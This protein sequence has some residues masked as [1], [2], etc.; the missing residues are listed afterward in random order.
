MQLFDVIPAEEPL[1]PILIS[2]PHSGVEFPSEIAEQIRPELVAKPN[3]TDWFVDQLYDFAPKMGITLIKANLS[4]Y[5][6][7]LNRSPEN[8]K[9]YNDDR[10][11]FDLVPK[12]QFNLESIYRDALPNAEEIE[13]RKQQ[14]F[15][16]YYQ[17]ISQLLQ[18]LRQQF[19]QVIFFD[20]HSIRHQVKAIDC[21][22]FPDLVLGDQNGKTAAPA[23]IQKTVE[24]L[25]A[26]PFEF[27]HNSPF[28]GGN[29]T[30]NFGCPDK[31]IHSLQLEMVQDIYMDEDTVLYSQEKACRIRPHLKK[32]FE[33]QLL[34]LEEM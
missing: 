1:R 30:R 22:R 3:D 12:Q 25:T 31:G 13:R 34:C 4:R 15:L 17:K 7:D 29:L 28:M 23:L 24:V 2:V 8:L 19:E 16:P 21:P 33:A 10:I 32:M 18:D 11:Q 27:S 6:I 20:A 14:Y 26:A 5:V 9:L